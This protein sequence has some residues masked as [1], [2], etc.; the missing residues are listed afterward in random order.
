LPESATKKITLRFA[1]LEIS[2]YLARVCPS[3]H[4][5]IFFF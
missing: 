3:V 4:Y 1:S 2:H 5:D